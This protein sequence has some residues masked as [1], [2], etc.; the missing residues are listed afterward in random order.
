M[1]EPAENN[2]RNSEMSQK[3]SDLHEA[4]FQHLVENINEVVYEIDKNGS[5]LYVSPAIKNL[6]GVNKEMFLGGSFLKLINAD[7][8]FME[9]RMKQLKKNKTLLGEYKIELP[10]GNTRYLRFF[11]RACFKNGEYTGGVGT[12]RDI[13]EFK[14]QEKRLSHLYRQHKLISAIAQLLTHSKNMEA[15]LSSIL[16]LTGE[17]LNVSRV[18][19]FEDN[20]EGTA[21]SNTFEWCNIGIVPQADELQNIPYSVIP[22]WKKIL[23][24]EGLIFSDHIDELPEDLI[25]VLEPQG[26][27]SLL[28]YPIV[29]NGN[30]LGFMGYDECN[31]HRDW[32]EGEFFMLKT[33]ANLIAGV[34]E[35]RSLMQKLEEIQKFNSKP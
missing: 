9:E 20:A 22:S 2:K 6:P 31:I 15:E 19:I 18:Y 3:Q 35:R 1:T 29:T 24:K 5:V 7:Q 34:F 21:S 32:S 16:K 27:K 25:K 8:R 12:I 26:I 33:L 4:R 17:H 11:T 10:E 14:Q 13:T 23:E 28:V 30:F